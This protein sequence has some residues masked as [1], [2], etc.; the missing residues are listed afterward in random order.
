M[1]SDFYGIQLTSAWLKSYLHQIVFELFLNGVLASFIHQGICS[2]SHLLIYIVAMVPVNILAS[3]FVL[4][5][6]YPIHVS[7]PVQLSLRSLA[8][9][10]AAAIFDNEPSPCQRW[11]KSAQLYG[12]CR[13]TWTL[14]VCVL[15]CVSGPLCVRENERKR[16]RGAL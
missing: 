10:G 6:F 4:M 11:G 16:E 5:H 12:C 9:M 8:G 2:F 14:C 7:A 13:S 15:S 1:G 3:P